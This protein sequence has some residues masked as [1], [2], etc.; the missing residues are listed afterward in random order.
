MKVFI[1]DENRI[2]AIGSTDDES[3]IPVKIEDDNFFIQGHSE[4]FICCFRVTL[5]DGVVTGM[6]AYRDSRDLDFID[7][8]GKENESL[9]DKALAADIL[10]GKVEV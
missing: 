10:L 8:I 5:T 9:Q 2:K 4:A 3:L 6:S 7:D 1:D